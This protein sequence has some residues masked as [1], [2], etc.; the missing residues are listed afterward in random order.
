MHFNLAAPSSSYTSPL[1]SNRPKDGMKSWP[2]EPPWKQWEGKCCSKSLC[3][4]NL[5]KMTVNGGQENRL[6]GVSFA[7]NMRR[8]TLFYWPANG[9][10]K[11]LM[12]PSNVVEH[13]SNWQTAGQSGWVNF[14]HSEAKQWDV[15]ASGSRP[16]LFPHRHLVN[17]YSRLLF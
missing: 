11:V 7:R 17:I 16:F 3:A 8:P 5:A 10:K 13:L 15:Q 2:K 4:R 9:N 12:Y 6:S 1:H 14:F